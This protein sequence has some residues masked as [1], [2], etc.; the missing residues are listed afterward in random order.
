MAADDSQPIG[1]FEGI[2][3]LPPPFEKASHTHT[4]TQYLTS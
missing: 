2:N 4:H 3:Y 1:V